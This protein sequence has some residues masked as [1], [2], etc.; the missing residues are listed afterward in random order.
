MCRKIVDFWGLSD[1]V[2]P[3]LSQLILARYVSKKPISAEYISKCVPYSRSSINS[4]LNQLE[5][6]QLVSHQI[7]TRQTGRGRKKKL[8]YLKG[9]LKDLIELGRKIILDRIESIKKTCI[10]V[11]KEI[12][13]SEYDLIAVLREIRVAADSILEEENKELSSP[14]I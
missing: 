3:V 6:L 2:T 12:D 10:R 5:S 11:S 1:N 7:D 9:D 8:Y 4:V 14:T 13:K